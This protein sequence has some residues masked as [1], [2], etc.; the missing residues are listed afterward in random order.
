[1]RLLLSGFTL[2]RI[3]LTVVGVSV[4]LAACRGTVPPTPEPEPALES[5]IVLPSQFQD[6]SVTAVGQPTGLAFTPDGRLLITE[7]PG[8][9]RV[10]ENSLQSA[11]ALDITS[12]VCSD[13]ERGLLSVAVDAQFAQNNFIYIYYTY[14]KP[15]SN[16][17]TG[18]SLVAVNRVSRFV[19]DSNNQV[20]PS[21]EVVL[22]DN[23]LSYAGNHNGGDLQFGK[24]GFLYVS[25]GDG[26]CD[27][28]G[29]SGCAGDN[30][31]AKDT[32]TLLGKILRITRDGAVPPGNPFTG[33]NSARCNTG[34][35]SAG[36]TCQETFATGLRNPFRM[37]FDPNPST[38]KFHINDV[39]QNTWEE[40]NLGQAGANYGWNTREGNCANGSRT[41]CGSVPGLTNPIYAYAQND[42]G[43][44]CASVTGGAFI[45]NG[46]WPASYDNG[47]LFADFVCGKIFL[48]KPSGSTFTATDFAT[49]LGNSS[50]VHMIF[51]PNGALYYTT[52][53]GGGQVR[54]IVYTGAANRA[55]VANFT[56]TPSSGGVPLPVTFDA[57]T[58]TDPDGDALSYSWNYGDGTTGAGK[59]VQKTYTTAGKKDVVLTV[60]D[61]KGATNTK[62]MAVFPGNAPPTLAITSPSASSQFR[63][64][65]FILLQGHASDAEDGTL[66]G[67]S[68]RWT[69]LLRHNSHTHP[70]KSGT[71]NSLTL[72]MAAPEDLAAIETSWLEVTLVATDSQGLS[73]SVTQKLLPIIVNT[74]FLSNPSGR[75]ITVNNTTLTTPRI[76]RSWAHYNLRVNAPNQSSYVFQSW[77]NGA[78]QSQI[79]KTP[80]GNASYIA[81]FR[82]Q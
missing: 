38:T 66:P 71:G 59:T 72:N 16:C 78:A 73:R 51:G 22:L 15:G 35:T 4:L 70:Y 37:A 8:R 29:N 47:Y 33:S 43:S 30:D 2:G 50:A 79:I 24:D 3:V 19:L 44:G 7:K 65:Q 5:Q 40:V 48:L 68:L 9:L 52:F 31:A 42:Q 69:V 54:R 10:Y 28:A 64:G 60:R 82:T 34:N 80:S 32:H 39:G 63:V 14:N 18:S 77:S 6:Q 45:P 58:S 27:Y 62:T 20:N 55:P 75:T 61:S 76:I 74:V 17:A 12:K 56:A 36:K 11:A 13:S 81:T 26:G 57:S 46:V 21:S 23:I 49:S 25:V 1:M 53:A 67:T 41:D